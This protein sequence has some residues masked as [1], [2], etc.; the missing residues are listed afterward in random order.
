[1]H[2]RQQIY[3]RISSVDHGVEYIENIEQYRYTERDY[4]I[5]SKCL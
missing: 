2:P 5:R 4:S 3:V 1:M